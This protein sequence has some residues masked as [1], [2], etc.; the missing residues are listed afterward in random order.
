[1][2][3]WVYAEIYIDAAGSRS[4]SADFA[5]AEAAYMAFHGGA[6][7]IGVDIQPFGNGVAC[8][9]RCRDI[10]DIRTAWHRHDCDRCAHQPIRAADAGGEAGVYVGFDHNISEK[11]GLLMKISN[12]CVILIGEVRC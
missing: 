2:S 8:R 10:P 1:M 3:G 7:Y 5:F 4:V 12:L 11:T 9:R 6:V